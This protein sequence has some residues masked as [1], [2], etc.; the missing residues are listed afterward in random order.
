V[1]SQLDAA[2]ETL[3]MGM[4]PVPIR[5]KTKVPTMKEWQSYRPSSKADLIHDFDAD[6]PGNIGVIL[7]VNNLTDVDFDCT[8]AVD[9]ADLFLPDTGFRFGRK[10]HP[11]SHAMYFADTPLLNQ[12]YKDVDTKKFGNIIELRGL[13]RDGTTG[14]QTVIPPSIHEKGEEI[15]FS[16]GVNRIPA[17][18]EADALEIAVARIA[19]AVELARYFPEAG[20]GRNEAFLAVNGALCKAKWSRD[21]MFNFS[22]A[23]RTI[24]Y[25]PALDRSPCHS[26]LDATM[27]NYE[28]GESIIGIPRLKECAT[29][30]KAVS[31]SFEWLGISE[32]TTAAKYED[33]QVIVRLPT[34]DTTCDAIKALRAANDPPVLFMQ[35]GAIVR[36]D[37]IENDKRIG[38][39]TS[40]R[41]ADRHYVRGEMERSAAYGK[42][43]RVKVGKEAFESQFQKCEVP[44]Q[45]VQDLM[46]RPPGEWGLPLLASVVESPVI[47]H[48]GRVI[49]KPG[50]DVGSSIF[51][52]Q[53]E[54]FELPPTMPESPTS[55]DAA[56]ARQFI[57]DEVL[58]DFP[59]VDEASRD[60]VLAGMV[61]IIARNA[62]VGPVPIG[63]IDAVAAGTG[64]GRL[65]EA[66]LRITTG[67]SP[68][69]VTYRRD[70]DAE[71]RKAITS[72][73]LANPQ[74]IIS[75]DNVMGKI[76]SDELAS[77]L[78]QSVRSDRLLGFN[79]KLELPVFVT[80]FANGNN[81]EIG[82]DIARRAYLIRM[83][84]KCE[85]PYERTGFK[86]PDLSG[87][88]MASRPTLIASLLVMCRAWFVAGKPVSSRP[89]SLG[90]FESWAE[91]VGGILD[92]A[93]ADQFMANADKLRSEADSEHTEWE[94]FLVSL[95]ELFGDK[96]FKVA[97]CVRRIEAGSSPIGSGGIQDVVPSCIAGCMS[98]KDTRNVAIG[99][100]FNFRRGRR[101]GKFRLE[102]SSGTGGVKRWCVIGE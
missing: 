74:S 14:Q 68:A 62:I 33:R 93:G 82:G 2:R 35:A 4:I 102:S 69:H 90:S 21:E 40:I 81:L 27:R 41:E 76:D 22:L 42:Q 52:S 45:V 47:A 25:G 66:I 50:Y 46:S 87:W 23:I 19:A 97:D 92:F 29:N 61:T 63:L 34:L 11:N 71:L 100:A 13:K 32:R 60:N 15:R 53:P 18:V 1:K 51:Y 38:K 72:T 10:S 67:K 91:V 73:L 89:V 80:W 86:H 88:I 37:T 55:E 77:S 75:F 3:A 56:R 24:L 57:E 9:I 101:F 26:E 70:D 36:I 84:A 20:N 7:G 39:I 30:P 54:G 43:R 5:L 99:K 17:K 85:K 58:V 59:F 6:N 44:M 96:P 98:K 65:M 31:K 48:D 49:A 78:T 16:S 28:E 95:H 8:D 83:D 12:A 79:R 64:K 94:S